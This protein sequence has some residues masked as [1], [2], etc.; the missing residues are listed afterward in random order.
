MFQK[1]A[2]AGRPVT[3]SRLHGD[4]TPFCTLSV[5][6]GR[7]IGYI[8]RSRSGQIQ[9]PSSDVCRYAPGEVPEWLNGAVSK[10]VVGASPPRVRI[11]LS[12]P[13]DCKYFNG[14]HTFVTDRVIGCFLRLERALKQAFPNRYLKIALI[15]IYKQIAKHGGVSPT[16]FNKAW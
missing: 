2:R 9:P 14:L 16:V 11:P 7:Q 5:A 1:P 3:S 10:T 12:P 6:S 4:G 8:S 15:E 13:L